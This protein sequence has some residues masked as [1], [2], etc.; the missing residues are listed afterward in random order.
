M[1][2]IQRRKIF[3]IISLL[4][5]IPG[6]VSLFTQGLNMGID[7]KGGSIIHVQMNESIASADVRDALSE[8]KLEQAE[9]QKS[10]DEFYI[11][12]QE[13]SQEQTKKMLDVLESKFN[14]VEFLSAE[15]V[16]P[17]IGKELTRNALLSMLIAGVLMLAY[18]TFRFELSFGIA[19]I[20][21]IIHN[22]LIVLSFFSFFQWEVNSS[23]I[24]AILTIIGY[25]INDTIVIFDR[26]RENLRLKLKD[27]RITL[28]NKSIMQTLNRSVNTVLTSVFPLLT[29]FLL[30]GSTIKIFVLA[31][32]IGFVT[33]AYSSIFIASPI[34]YEIKSKA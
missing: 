6:L 26:V 32:L 29:L 8:L 5:I 16:G 33:G 20:A 17:T 7:F 15:S 24:A 31:M 34:W 27:E 12:T 13:L 28:L 25:S 18:I 4:I 19:A 11:R 22:I 14:K 2:I 3:Y 21:A 23:F 30:G 9:V 1:Q 10:G